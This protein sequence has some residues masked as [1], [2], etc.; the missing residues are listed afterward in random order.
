MRLRIA[1]TNDGEDEPA[2]EKREHKESVG[3]NSL[4]RKCLEEGVVYCA[5]C[6]WEMS[7]T[8]PQ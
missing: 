4:G 5:K 3:L 7:K 1:D 6:C 8:Q 2:M